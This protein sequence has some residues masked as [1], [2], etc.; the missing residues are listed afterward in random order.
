M[1]KVQKIASFV[2]E[3]YHNT[4]GI[5]YGKFTDITVDI[6]NDMS[7]KHY[8]SYVFYIDFGECSKYVRI[9]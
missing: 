8:K 6:L 9:W 1:G 5:Y 4:I 2:D 3:Y 7:Y